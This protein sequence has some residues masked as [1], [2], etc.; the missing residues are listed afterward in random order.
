MDSSTKVVAIAETIAEIPIM[1][2][3]IFLAKMEA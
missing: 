2:F 1:F 3:F